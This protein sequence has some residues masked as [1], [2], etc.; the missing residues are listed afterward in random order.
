MAS[1]CL[2]AADVLKSMS[3]DAAVASVP[4]LKPLDESAIATLVRTG[5]PIVTVEEHILRG[6]L[7]ASIASLLVSD[8]KRPVLAGIAIPEP[9]GKISKGGDRDQLLN[10]AGLSAGSIVSKV[11]A[12]LGR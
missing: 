10:D 4:C 12:V 8:P 11:R 7:Y 6:G 3:I 2:A 5:S 9:T 1:L